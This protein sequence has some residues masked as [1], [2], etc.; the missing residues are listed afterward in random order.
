MLT[1][2]NNWSSTNINDTRRIEEAVFGG[3]L[4]FVFWQL[5][6]GSYD[7][8][9]VGQTFVNWYGPPY[10][11][12]GTGQ[13]LI[14]NI[15]LDSVPIFFIALKGSNE[16][17]YWTTEWAKN[18]SRYLFDNDLYLALSNSEEVRER[19]A[20]PE[21][22]ALL[23]NVLTKWQKQLQSQGSYSYSYLQMEEDIKQIEDLAKTK[24]GITNSSDF[25]NGILGY[26]EKMAS[27]PTK[28]ILGVRVADPNNW[29]YVTVLAIF[30]I[31][32]Y[33]T[34]LFFAYLRTKR[35]YSDLKHLLEVVLGLLT[36]GLGVLIYTSPYDYQVFSMQTVVGVLTVIV[37]VALMY[38]I[39]KRLIAWRAMTKQNDSEDTNNDAKTKTKNA[40]KTEDMK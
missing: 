8:L 37:G 17:A 22:T 30:P 10:E 4:S 1:P 25:I 20:E 38:G 23:Q 7:C 18:D 16:T 19:Y 33:V 39:K 24:Y 40:N 12:L 29:L 21:L 27:P 31:A 34:Y 14:E 3:N 32:I 11:V 36:C 26:L 6:N 28:T 35:P 9:S 15:T 13:V 5:S 2:A